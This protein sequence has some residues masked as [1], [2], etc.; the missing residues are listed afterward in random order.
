MFGMFGS[1]KIKT[2]IFVDTTIALRKYAGIDLEKM[3][4]EEQVKLGDDAYILLQRYEK[5]RKY[6]KMEMI[7]CC[8]AILLA[9]KYDEMPGNILYGRRIELL[10]GI[11]D[12]LM[13]P[14]VTFDRE[15]FSNDPRYFS[16][17]FD[18][19]IIRHLE[20]IPDGLSLSG[21]SIEPLLKPWS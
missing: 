7:C 5:K 4:M 9:D 6:T 16:P 15:P 19:W 14:E 12:F 17:Y 11:A 8:L 18:A 10:K 1:T 20:E 21:K 3:S 13:S 2:Y